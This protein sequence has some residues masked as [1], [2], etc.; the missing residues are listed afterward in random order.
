MENKF[1][2]K[3]IQC[4]IYLMKEKKGEFYENQ[5]KFS[6]FLCNVMYFIY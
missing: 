5:E 1:D 2:I 4:I 3:N 6:N